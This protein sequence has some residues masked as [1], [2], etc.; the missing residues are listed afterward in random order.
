MTLA[1]SLTKSGPLTAP[2]SSS[3]KTIPRAESK[4]QKLACPPSPSPL[5]ASFFSQ[6]G[7]SCPWPS[8][9][10]PIACLEALPTKI[11]TLTPSRGGAGSRRLSGCG[12][13]CGASGGSH[14]GGPARQHKDD[15]AS[16]LS[17]FPDRYLPRSLLQHQPFLP[18]T[19]LSSQPHALESASKEKPKGILFFF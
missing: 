3:F 10:L 19:D 11:Q 6:L 16:S 17:T 4:T 18:V 9:P 13:G 8:S 7:S 5:A 12:Q 14:Q 2:C 1:S 15:S